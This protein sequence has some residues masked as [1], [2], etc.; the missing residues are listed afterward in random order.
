M[1][2]PADTTN[3]APAAATLTAAEAAKCVFRERPKLDKEG[4]PTDEVEKL[5]VRADEVLA[6]AVRG[7]QV[8]VVTTTG[9]KLFGD[10]PKKAAK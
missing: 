10:L 9:E 3:A 5:A 4:K 6:S 7:D 8:T 1:G 2:D